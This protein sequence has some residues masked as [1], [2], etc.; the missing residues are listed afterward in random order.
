MSIAR[1]HVTVTDSVLATTYDIYYA[2]LN[3]YD[4]DVL[5]QLA[6]PVVRPRDGMHLHCC[7]V[8]PP[9]TYVLSL[10]D[11]ASTRP[12]RPSVSDSSPYRRKDDFESEPLFIPQALSAAVEKGGRLLVSELTGYSQD[13]TRLVFVLRESNL[14]LCEVYFNSQP[15]HCHFAPEIR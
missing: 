1:A 11:L 9:A 14:E 5:N 2:F 15:E 3:C 4:H 7:R 6:I 13:D 8:A 10:D 12:S